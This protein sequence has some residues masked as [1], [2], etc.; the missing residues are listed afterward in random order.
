MIS[1]VQIMEDGSTIEAGIIGNDGILGYPAY[2]GGQTM[3]S[4]AIVQI[5]GSAIAL[6]AAILQSE[7]VRCKALHHIL[8][9]YTQA[10]LAQVSQT[11]A[12]NRFHP[13]EER[14]ARWLSQ[15]RDF[16]QSDTLQLT[17]D[18]LSSMLGT[19]RASVTVAAGTLQQAGLIDY[20]RG[21]IQILDSKGLKS[22]CCECYAVVQTEYRR[23]LDSLVAEP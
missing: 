7:F 17:Q 5:A 2:L 4:R 19:R 13:V 22:A 1:L 18:F 6:D 9:L 20:N 14:L 23:L 12:C 8:L 21:H 11:A 16:S 3:S 15:S 10:F